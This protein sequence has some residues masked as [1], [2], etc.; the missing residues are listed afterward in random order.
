MRKWTKV[1]FAP[2][3]LSFVVLWHSRSQWPHGPRRWSAA[4]TCWGC[5]FESRRG[6]DVCLL[7]VCV[8]SGRGLC[9]GLITRPEESYR[10]RCVW[11]NVIMKP[12]KWGGPGPLGAVV[13]RK[14]TFSG[15][16]QNKTRLASFW[17]LLVKSNATDLSSVFSEEMFSRT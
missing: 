2:C 14:K 1:N 10:M 11:L 9:V 8:L 4:I 17:C 6:M 15:I 16:G 7:W 12:R 13:Q 5:G 3:N